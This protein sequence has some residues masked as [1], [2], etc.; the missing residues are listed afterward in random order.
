MQV[1]AP[2]DDDGRP[3]INPEVAV[4]LMLAGLITSIVHDR[5]LMRDAQV[6]IAIRWRTRGIF[7]NHRATLAKK[8]KRQADYWCTVLARVLSIAKDDGLI[9]TNPCEKA[10]RL[11]DGTRREIVWSFEGE[12]LCCSNAPEHLF[13][14]LLMGAWTGQREGDLL[15]LPRSAYDG[16]THQA[17]P[18]Q[19]RAV[20][21]NPGRRPPQSGTRRCR[22]GQEG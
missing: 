18:V 4:R 11:Y 20:C 15:R 17:A 8:S 7:K 9:S 16:Q 19:D 14:L 5:R 22:A 21:R 12:E 3:G 13:L 10:G 1:D 6:N 2:L